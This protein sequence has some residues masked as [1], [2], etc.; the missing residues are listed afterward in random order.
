MAIPANRKLRIVLMARYHPNSGDHAMHVSTVREAEIVLKWG[1]RLL[2]LL[3]AIFGVVSMFYLSYLPTL[4]YLGAVLCA[5]YIALIWENY[6]GKEKEEREV[7]ETTHN[8]NIQKK[9]S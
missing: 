4:F 1:Y 7:A 3:V 8:M 2:Y 5:F 6:Q 9:P